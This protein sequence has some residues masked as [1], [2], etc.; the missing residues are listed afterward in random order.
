MLYMQILDGIERYCIRISVMRIESLDIRKLHNLYDYSVQFKPDLTF[1][2]GSNGCGKTTILNIIESIVSGRIYDLY[3]W[4]FERIRL[5]YIDDEQVSCDSMSIQISYNNESICVTFNGTNRTI[6]K[7]DYI[8][9]CEEADS[10]AELFHIMVNKYDF[11]LEIKEEF[12]YVYLPLNRYSGN[13]ANTYLYRKFMRPVRL[14][15]YYNDFDEHGPTR[16][17]EIGRA[18]EL[19]QKS[20]A[21][22][23]AMVRTIN[24]EF[25]NSVL[26]SLLETNAQLSNDNFI[27]FLVASTDTTNLDSLKGQ[28]LKLL[29]SL[30]LL[31]EN[32]KDKYNQFFQHYKK[33]V[34]NLKSAERKKGGIPVPI[35]LIYDYHEIEKI[36]TV[37]PLAQEAE[38]KKAEAL[39]RINLFVDT[40]N[41]FICLDEGNKEL[42]IDDTG[43]IKFSSG[44]KDINISVNN[45]SS[46]EKQLLIFFANL[47]FNVNETQSSIFVVDEPELS[48]HLSWQKMF[49]DKAMMI[50]Q[51]MQLI[52]ATHAPEIVG[53]HRN[54]MVKLVKKIH[55]ED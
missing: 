41:S 39:K 18:A 3:A 46:G 19:V 10:F 44:G 52:F 40:M 13:S 7:E 17:E 24:D 50:N 4:D 54:K 30:E 1:L 55:E 5:N 47:V 27:Q 35:S 9:C 26:K 43:K 6:K 20:Y 33:Q 48:L 8:R 49:I 31:D 22:A 2:Y 25:R 15:Y 23:S 37:I 38:E 14:R 42:S 34:N 28:Y 51:N 21:K 53:R 11:L 36:K 45:L 32:E 12:N 16:E 29:A